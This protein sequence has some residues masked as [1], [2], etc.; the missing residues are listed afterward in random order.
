VPIQDLQE[1]LVGL[2]FPPAPES[3]F[4]ARAGSVACE[5][6]TEHRTTATFGARGE[7]FSHASPDFAI[8]AISGRRPMRFSFVL[9]VGVI[10]RCDT[11]GGSVA[12]RPALDLPACRRLLNEGEP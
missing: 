4:V 12:R 7:T 11:F 8:T 9:S 2:G 1:F 5:R 10:F 3:R 6:G